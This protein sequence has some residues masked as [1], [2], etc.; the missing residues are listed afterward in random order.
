MKTSA[1]FSTIALSV[2]LSVCSSALLARDLGVV[3]PVYPIAEQD[4]LATIEQRLTALKQSGDLTRLEEDA[5]A[6]YQAYVERPEGVHLPRA[7][8]TRTYYVDPGITVPYDI[9]DHEGRII[10]PAGTTVNPLDHITLS[11]QLMFFDGD[12]PVQV[13][14]ARSMIDSNPLRLKPILTNGPVLELMDE[15]KLRLYVDQRGQLVEHFA[16]QAIPAV[17]SQ[18]G[19]RLK[20]VEHGLS[21]P[22]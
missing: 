16:I 22:E 8:K 15:W 17:V 14:W 3:G 6:R 4:M 2:A 18:E 12:D 11:K 5:K 1:G 19:K 21:S 10:H 9:T 7:K 13:E 20:V